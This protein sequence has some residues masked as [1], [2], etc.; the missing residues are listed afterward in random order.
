MKKITYILFLALIFSQSTGGYPGAG[1]RYGTNAREV[2]M[3]GS[4]NSVYNKGFNSFSNPA[5]LSKV[6]TDEYGLS[7]FSMSL[8]RSIQCFSISAPL[9]P[10]ASASLSVMRVGTDDIT[11]T[12]SSGN[13]IDEI[14]SYEGYGM[15]SFGNQFGKLAI[16]INIKA[17]KNQLTSSYSADGIGVDLGM[18]YTLSNY[19]VFGLSIQNLSSTYNWNFD[20]NNSNIQYEESL[21]QLISLGYSFTSDKFLITGQGDALFLNHPDDI[22]LIDAE[23]FTDINENESYDQGEPFE[24]LD[25]DGKWDDNVFLENKIEF[26]YRIGTEVN[27]LNIVD[28]PLMLRMGLY[29]SGGKLQYALGCGVPFDLEDKI[30]LEFNY[31]LDPGIM[32]EGLSH[33][34][35]FSVL[36]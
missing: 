16:G 32:G 13:I 17:F 3:G 23:E 36:N 11:T 15:L 21:P 31:A 20:Y 8:D 2:S 33:L 5:L 34:I 10:S 18:I 29:Y 35:T 27:M 1:F 14:G 7:Y 4:M 30:K 12:N 28:I 25:D 9:P 26:S 22:L 19:S 6:K 24:D